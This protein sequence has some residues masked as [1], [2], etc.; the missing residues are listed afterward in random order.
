VQRFLR[1]VRQPFAVPPLARGWERA[2]PILLAIGTV[3]VLGGLTII[4][5]ARLTVDRPVYVSELGAEGAPTAGMFRVALLLVAAGGFSIALASGHVRSRIRPLDRWAP[6]L[7]LGFAAL[8]FVV[9]SQVT[10]TANCPVPIAD[11]RSTAQDLTHTVSAV[12]GFVAAC[13]AM[14]QVAFAAR[15]PR[16]ARFS[17]AS[18]VAVAVIT[19]VGGMLAIVHVATD[20]G[21]WLELIGTTV[22]IAW[23]A[24]F[25]LALSRGSRPA[26]EQGQVPEQ[27][28]VR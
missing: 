21:A 3:A 15:L 28:R 25:A 27:V 12:L 19:I 6:A 14:L 2:V 22:A 9:A 13:Y 20:V 8:C 7:S 23:I 17:L 1:I 10:C 18:C 11:P 26:R 16:V 4:W 5:A 24:A